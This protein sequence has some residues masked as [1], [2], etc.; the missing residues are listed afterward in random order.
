[1]IWYLYAWFLT[2]YLIYYLYGAGMPLMYMLAVI[3]FIG[4]Y[5]NYKFLFFYWH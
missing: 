1:M 5:L 3:F 2:N 4:S